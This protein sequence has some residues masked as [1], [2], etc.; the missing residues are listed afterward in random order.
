MYRNRF[1]ELIPDCAVV[2][3]TQVDNF[4]SFISSSSIAGVGTSNG[5]VVLIVDFSRAVDD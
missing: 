1:C 5:F 3:E 4:I 2:A